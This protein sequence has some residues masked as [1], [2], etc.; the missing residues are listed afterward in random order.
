MLALT[1]LKKINQDLMPQFNIQIFIHPFLHLVVMLLLP[2][3]RTTLYIKEYLF[4]HKNLSGDI[5]WN[6][7]D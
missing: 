1:E 4:Q 5:I 3:L 6:L 7:E 2:S